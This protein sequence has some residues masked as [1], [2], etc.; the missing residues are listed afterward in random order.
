MGK[1]FF[2]KAY[3][4]ADIENNIPNTVDTKFR[5][6]S[7]NKSYTDVLITQMVAKGKLSFDDKLSSFNLGFPREIGDKITLRHILTHSAG[8]SDI[9]IPQYLKHIRDYKRY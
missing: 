3:G 2:E 4:L 5:I 7:I 8:F 1:P 6:G 9:F